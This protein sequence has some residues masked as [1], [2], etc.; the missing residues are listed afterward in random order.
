MI[1]RLSA[2][3]SPSGPVAQVN[4]EDPSGPATDE[5]VVIVDGRIILSR[6]SCPLQGGSQSGLDPFLEI[7]MNRRY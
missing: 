2:G 7:P 3:G 6:A 4:I 1:L 5:M